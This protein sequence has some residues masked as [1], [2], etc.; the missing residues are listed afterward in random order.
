M[1]RSREIFTFLAIALLL[2]FLAIEPAAPQQEPTD[3]TDQA[4]SPPTSSKKR[5]K[6]ALL[7]QLPSSYRDWLESV[8]LIIT[9]EEKASFLELE[10]DY[11]RDAFIE[12][13]WKARDP[14]PETSRNEFR[15]R[16]EAQ[17]AE[18]RERFGSLTE[19][20]SRVLL[21][22]ESPDAVLPI[23]CVELWPAEVWYWQRNRNVGSELAILF[24]QR[25]GGGDYRLWYPAE[26]LPALLK[27][28]ATDFFAAI[29]VCR[30]QDIDALY[31]VLKLA[32]FVGEMGFTTMVAQLLRTPE[33]P[34]G[35]WV[36]TFNAYST[37]L[38]KDAVTFPAEL[39]VD[40]PGRHQ[41]RTVVQGVL[42]VPRS[43]ADVSQLADYG[44]TYNFLLTGEV[45]REERLFDTF[46][47]Q[48]N[49]P[50]SQI[51]SEKIPLVFERYLR[52]GDYTLILKLEDLN[53]DEEHREVAELSVPEMQ[54]RVPSEPLDPETARILAEANAAI[55]TGDN[56]IR[57]VPP[58]GQYQT[59]LM[60]V[61]TL[62]TGKDIRQV[63]FNL[64]GQQE[65]IKNSPPWSV[66]LDLGS[67][68]RMRTLT[69]IGLDA[70]GNELA[71]DQVHLNAGTHRFDVRLV[72]P[73]RHQVYRHSLRAEA[74]VDLPEGGS[75]ERVEFY[76]NE[77]LVATLFQP[78]WTQPILLNSEGELAYVR[79]VAY[80]PDGN[81]IEDTV[82]INAPD[83]MENLEIQFVELYI[84]V[85]DRDNHP[86]L[87]LDKQDFQVFEDGA[88][89]QT[90]RFDRV[91]NLPIHAGI[92]LDVSASMEKSLRT[93]QRAALTFFEQAIGAKDRATLMTFNDHPNLAVKF[94][95][96]LAS[97]AG[98]LSG[99]KAERG[100]ALYDSV[101]FAL[102]Y[103][104]GIKGQRAL[105]L[106]SDGK[107]EHSRFGWEDT[108]E[109]ARRAGV[110]IYSIGLGL[111]RKNG[112]AKRKLVKLAEETG[113]RSFFIDSVDELA[114]IYDTIQQELRSRYYLAYQ[115]TNTADD[116]AFRT[117]EVAVA[118][119]GLEAKTLR[120]YYP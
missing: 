46:R 15:E 45:L 72:E 74:K 67:L 31:A 109:Y 117:I 56:T 65:L 118:G 26:G 95:N 64:D 80:Q 106:L 8:D 70:G 78:P 90:R 92:L 1:L 38:D 14:Y 34:S 97:L 58:R 102:Y 62:T 93:A 32:R 16:Y 54:N 105:I 21:L 49:I 43:E 24:Y 77:T 100:T 47:Y 63:I 101:I 30:Q 52:P 115:S 20:R 13:F 6:K 73:R 61:D 87:G 17:V 35:E 111:G 98:G 81:F 50:A 23:S 22:N 11:Q 120:G 71:R 10:K 4:A 94:T 36:A 40:Y 51:E 59:G 28:A 44:G 110:S 114:T 85:L 53:S 7:Q 103:F 57:V 3:D 69:V 116:T 37:E 75:V 5:S 112:D 60:R 113:G 68:P 55:S 41:N 88:Q 108:V 19:D 104:N 84:T 29:E 86:V 96:E 99:L 82:W 66:E 12:R 2:A 48:F 39:E 119:Q 79:V 18:A 27:F 107:D 42:T 91:S 33:S 89:Q 76:L 9:K 25:G 83:Y